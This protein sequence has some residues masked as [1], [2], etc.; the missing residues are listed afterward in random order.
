MP[1]PDPELDAGRPVHEVLAGLGEPVRQLV[2]ANHILF[3]GRW[4]DLAEDIRRRQAGRP[5][6]FKLDLALDA[7]LAWI[8]RLRDYE[9]ARGERLAAAIPA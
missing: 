8:G 1:R 4:D 5:Y 6:L 7:P 2:V 3:A 9:A